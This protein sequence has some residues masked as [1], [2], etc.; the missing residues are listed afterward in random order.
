MLKSSK[1]RAKRVLVIAPHPDDEVLATGGVIQEH[2]RRGHVV[3]VVL[4]T[5]GDGQRR[6]PF[7]PSRHFRKLGER[8][9]HES[10]EALSLLGLRAERVIALGYPDRGLAHLWDSTPY[11]SKYTKACAVPYPW[12]W[13]PHAPYTKASLLADLQEIVSAE[14]PNVIYIPHP[15]DRHSD[16]RAAYAFT[17]Y[18]LEE[19][20][21]LAVRRYY[22]I[23]HGAWPLPAG[24]HP[25]RHLLPPRALKTAEW[26]MHELRPDQI[27]RKCTAISKYRTQTRYFADRLFSF[28]RRNELFALP[29]LRTPKIKS[30]WAAVRAARGLLTAFRQA[31]N[32]GQLRE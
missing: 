10:L 32:N 1:R 30:R 3:K 28:A 27:E 23:H 22:L 20:K 9:Y 8:R 7:L 2:L 15:H 4:I 21:L 13:Q 6:G 11:T 29:P 12:A 14:C 25:Q 19:A 5:C 16:H 24:K 17:T 18:A 26:L 31:Q